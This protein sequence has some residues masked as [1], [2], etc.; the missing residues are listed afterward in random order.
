[1][2][3]KKFP[4]LVYQD[5]ALTNILVKVEAI[6]IF[7]NLTFLENYYI[8]DE[9][10]PES[11]S[12][13]LYNTVDY[14]WTFL[15]IN[16]MFNREYD[17]PL[18]R[19]K[20]DELMQTKYS[21]S[22]VFISD[23]SINFS[24]SKVKKINN[25]FVKSYDRDINKFVLNQKVFPSQLNQTSSL[26]LYDENGDKINLNPITNN[27]FRIVYEE[28]FSLHSFIEDKEIINSRK[29]VNQSIDYLTG[30]INKNYNELVE[31]KVRTIVN[32]ENDLNDKKRNI[33]YIRPSFIGVFNSL[34]D[35]ELTRIKSESIN[36][37]E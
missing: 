31:S 36:D 33:L 35:K 19:Q 24:F 11:L 26:F 16:E 18:T 1:M 8:K 7:K 5:K 15:F 23:S 34:I 10:T 12:Y 21:N 27:N 29:N 14:S 4:E 25:F 32:Y 22:C 30:Y 37:A 17:W 2:Y 28:A 13:N 20:F 3:F 6:N 9:D